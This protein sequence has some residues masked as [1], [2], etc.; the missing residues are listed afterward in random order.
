LAEAYP[1]GYTTLGQ[2]LKQG[3]E[4]GIA[5]GLGVSLIGPTS[6]FIRNNITYHFGFVQPDAHSV[7]TAA[8]TLMIPSNGA[9]LMANLRTR[10][11]V[12]REVQ[13]PCG[14][15]TLAMADTVAPATMARPNTFQQHSVIPARP[16]A[17]LPQV[18]ES[19][20]RLTAEQ[21]DNRLHQRQKKPSKLSQEA[22]ELLQA[23]A[24]HPWAPAKTLWEAT[25]GIPSPAVQNKVRLNLSIKGLGLADSGEIRL[26]SANCLLYELTD[27]GWEFFGRS[28]PTRQGRGGR[29]HR[30]I[31]QWIRMDGETQGYKAWVEWLVPGSSHPADVACEI[32]P[33]HFHVFEVS[34]TA[35]DNLVH[36]LNILAACP[37]IDK[38]TIVCTQKRYVEELKKT[39]KNEPVV[40]SLGA[41]LNY[42]LAE[43]FMRRIFP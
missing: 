27:K 23:I 31:S 42:A 41:K 13:G 1:E 35:T 4:F 32:S 2:V 11:F 8:A 26:G 21:Q 40:A 34:V 16:L 10:E 5:A 18:R 36:H 37:M 22:H 24:T 3:R 43:E 30:F 15:T 39:L 17:E 29:P 28:A 20:Q 6:A 14:I 7:S 19:L 12:F 33:N 9:G 25:T 38:I